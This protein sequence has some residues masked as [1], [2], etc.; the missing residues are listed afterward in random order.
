VG[1][2]NWVKDAPSSRGVLQE[3]QNVG[4]NRQRKSRQNLIGE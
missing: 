4:S 2:I 1:S 3:P